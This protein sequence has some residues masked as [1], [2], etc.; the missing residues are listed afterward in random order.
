MDP[1]PHNKRP[2]PTGRFRLLIAEYEAQ[3]NGTLLLSLWQ[4]T[5]VTQLI[6]TTF[7]NMIG[8]G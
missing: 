5:S 2:E 3:V 7:N 4:Y 6:N 1:Q 8:S